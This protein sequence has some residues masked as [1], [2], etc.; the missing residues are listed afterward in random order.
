VQTYVE[1]C[2]LFMELRSLKESL[3]HKKTCVFAGFRL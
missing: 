2:T 1:A 3:L